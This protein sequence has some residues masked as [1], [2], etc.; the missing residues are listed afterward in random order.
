MSGPFKICSPFTQTCKTFDSTS[1]D[2][3]AALKHDD[4]LQKALSGKSKAQQSRMQSDDLFNNYDMTTAD[5]IG[6][7]SKRALEAE[8]KQKNNP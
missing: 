5:Y 7:G 2:G 3:R 4:E 8:A 6:P 1:F